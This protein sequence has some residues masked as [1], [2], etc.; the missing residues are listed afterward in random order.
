MCLDSK[1]RDCT[2]VRYSVI[3]F[4]VDVRR[5]ILKNAGG[6]TDERRWRRLL[7][8]S[9]VAGAVSEAKGEPWDAFADRYGDPGRE[10]AIVV[11]RK[12]CGLTLREIG[13]HAGMKD[14]AVSYAC[15]AIGK[16]LKKDRE[17][18]LL[19]QRVLEKL[20]EAEN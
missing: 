9:A 7:P 10:L 1:I 16:R 18:G 8:F 15:A 13:E 5:R 17:L 3:C 20:G 4:K 6:R 14:K 2:P 11:A 19:Y 12:R